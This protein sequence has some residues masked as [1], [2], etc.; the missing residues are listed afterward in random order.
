[1]LNGF[2]LREQPVQLMIFRHQR[3]AAGKDDLIQFRVCGDIL[4]RDCP[5]ALIALILR[6]REVTTETVAAI[7]RTSAFYQQ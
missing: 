5:V 2:Q 7:Y 6:I 4:Q 1:M 3:I